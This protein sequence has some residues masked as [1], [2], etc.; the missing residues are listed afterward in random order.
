L[1][2]GLAVR[3]TML[4][5]ATP[6]P[7]ETVIVPIYR[8]PQPPEP[9]TAQSNARPSNGP[10]TRSVLPPVSE[11]EPLGPIDVTIGIPEPGTIAI[12]S[13]GD[14]GRPTELVGRAGGGTPNVAGDG[15][16]VEGDVDIPI[17]A[18]PGTGNPRYPAT[19]QSAGLEGDVR[20]QF[21]VDTLGRVERGSV[22]VLD[23]THEL[24][25]SAVRDALTRAHFK[26]AVAG[27]R[28]VR[29]LAEQTFTFRITK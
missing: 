2:I 1:L 4:T 17:L 8:P 7:K 21:V 11:L 29:Q 20:A 27:G 18:I 9:N 14:F 25:A 6:R 22:R 12:T 23:T 24:F 19:L 13:A 28:L 10:T 26:P 15:P 5:A 16:R 3:A